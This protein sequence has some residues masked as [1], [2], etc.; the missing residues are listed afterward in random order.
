MK[1]T[2]IMVL[3]VLCS[4]NIYVLARYVIW[5]YSYIWDF[6]DIRN[7][8]LVTSR[9][10]LLRPLLHILS[11]PVKV[12]TVPSYLTFWKSNLTKG[13]RIS[14]GKLTFLTAE[15]KK[16]VHV[17]IKSTEYAATMLGLKCS[18]Y[19]CCCVFM[20]EPMSPT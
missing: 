9:V 19:L 4:S 2:A 3:M 20:Y 12:V 14:S 7:N 15:L 17:E 10:C 1:T 13:K 16:S 5:V 8:I 11:L 18:L 6:I